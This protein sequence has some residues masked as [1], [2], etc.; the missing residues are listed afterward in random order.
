MGRWAVKQASRQVDR[1][2]GGQDRWTGGCARGGEGMGGRGLEVEAG[3]LE[4]GGKAQGDN[5]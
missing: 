2:A 5:L 4:E 3:R 1:W